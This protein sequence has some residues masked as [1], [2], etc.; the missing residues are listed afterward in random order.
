M[1]PATIQAT[2]TNALRTAQEFYTALHALDP[3]DSNYEEG[4]EELTK[5][6]SNKFTRLADH[7]EDLLRGWTPDTDE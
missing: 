3:N 1:K 2:I 4:L 6:F 7:A 5:L